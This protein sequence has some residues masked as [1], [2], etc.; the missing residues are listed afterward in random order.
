MF[1]GR[2]QGGPGRPAAGRTERWDVRIL[3]TGNPR[4]WVKTGSW[5]TPRSRLRRSCRRWRTSARRSPAPSRRTARPGRSRH[6][7]SC[8]SRGPPA[9]RRP[10]WRQV[11]PD[12]RQLR[13]VAVAAASTPPGADGHG[14]DYLS[15]LLA[16]DGTVQVSAPAVRPYGQAADAPNR[17]FPGHL[18]ETVHGTFTIAGC[19]ASEHTG[20]QGLWRAGILITE[21]RGVLTTPSSDFDGIRRHSPYPS[22]EYAA[23]TQTT[24]REM[25]E[26]TSSVVSRLPANVLRGLDV[27]RRFF[28]YADPAEIFRNR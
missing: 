12:N 3:V 27:D 19:L 18:L 25:A 10:A 7:R 13:P 16:D 11:D 26:R 22:K 28:P 8:G 6:R 24:T 15:A 1:A 2:R 23:T 21:L 9:G 5:C 4:G 14:V 17:R 20:Y